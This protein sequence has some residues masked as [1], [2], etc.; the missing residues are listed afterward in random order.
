MVFDTKNSTDFFFILL[1]S[2]RARRCRCYL[3]ITSTTMRV[4]TILHIRMYVLYIY[5]YALKILFH[6][7]L[8]LLDI[9]C[10]CCYFFRFFFFFYF[11]TF[12][13]IWFRKYLLLRLLLLFNSLPI[14]TINFRIFIREHAFFLFR[15]GKA[16]THTIGTDRV[17]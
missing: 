3:P 6:L 10:C 8:L 15:Y 1:N 12:F 14:M 4:V 13:F 9:S 16:Y 11:S 5:V 2:I 7:L 17:R